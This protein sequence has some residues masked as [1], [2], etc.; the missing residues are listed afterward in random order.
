MQIPHSIFRAWKTRL[1]IPILPTQVMMILAVSLTQDEAATAIID[2][3][4][5]VDVGQLCLILLGEV[6]ASQ[7]PLDEE[8]GSSPLRWIYG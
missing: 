5:N 2:E 4:G 3:P 7:P 1:Q 6:D 8:F